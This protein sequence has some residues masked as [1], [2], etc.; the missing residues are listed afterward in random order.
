MFERTP[1]CV[2][3]SCKMGSLSC[4]VEVVMEVQVALCC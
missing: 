2:V 3:A 4:Y 1:P